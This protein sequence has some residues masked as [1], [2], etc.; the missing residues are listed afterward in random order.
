MR[1]HHLI[2]VAGIALLC[3]S[4]VA[5]SKSSDKAAAQA[6]ESETKVAIAGHT[7][8][9]WWCKEHGVPEEVCAQCDSKLVA[10]FKALSATR[11]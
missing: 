3:V 1:V 2:T 4:T 11:V 10:D 6:K 9:G 7:H 8:D 5:C